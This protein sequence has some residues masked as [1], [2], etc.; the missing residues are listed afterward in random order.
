M[1]D[2]ELRPVTLE[3]ALLAY[4]ALWHGQVAVI[5]ERP[6]QDSDVQPLKHEQHRLL[7]LLAGVAETDSDPAAHFCEAARWHVD[8]WLIEDGQVVCADCT[9]GAGRIAGGWYDLT[10]V[11]VHMPLVQEALRRVVEKEGK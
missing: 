4:Q 2:I 5:L 3:A 9:P 1:P 10:S 8:D 6:M 11:M 7:C